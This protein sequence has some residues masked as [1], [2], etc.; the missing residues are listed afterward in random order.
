MKR[1]IPKTPEQNG[2]A[3]RK[4]RTL[5]EAVCTMIADSNLSKTFWGEALSTAVYVQNRGPTTA[6][7]GITLYQILN[8]RK[9]NVKHFRVFGCLAFAHVPK[10]ERGKLDSKSRKCVLLGYGSV[11]KGYRL[12]V[13]Y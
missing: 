2:I 13:W 9:P 6:L 12:Y 5:V 10:E 11:T 3:E 8:D 1:L 4:N 7:N